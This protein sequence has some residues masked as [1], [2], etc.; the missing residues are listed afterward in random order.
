[1]DSIPATFIDLFERKTVAHLA[2]VMPDG[3]PQVT[4]V[5]IDRDD[6]GYV[7]VNTARNRQKE[8]N[9]RQNEKVGLSIPDPEDPYRY[10]SV[11]GEVEDVT[12]D[13]AVEHIDE[14]TRRYFEREEYPHH[15]EEVGERVILR[16]R[17]DR[18]V[19]NGD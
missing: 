5:W 10:L 6:D 9:V 18:V 12:A 8:R 14:L 19:T 2:T 16:I 1:M 17:P 15:G 11:R 7:L 3:T 4:P 13:G